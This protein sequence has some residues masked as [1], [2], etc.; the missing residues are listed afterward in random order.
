MAHV[1]GVPNVY[2][3]YVYPPPAE[4]HLIAADGMGLGGGGGGYPS[5]A[6]EL[7]HMCVPGS[8]GVYM[9]YSS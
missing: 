6:I 1:P 9:T 3:D 8:Q 2:E 7:G 4:G 5:G